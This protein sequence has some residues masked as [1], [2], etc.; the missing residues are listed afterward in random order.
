[1]IFFK[2]YLI[3]TIVITIP[4]LI[5][6]YFDVQRMEELLIKQ[7]EQKLLEIGIMLQQNLS[8]SF[9]F[10]VD[11]ENNPNLKEEEKVK[12]LN[13]KIQPIIMKISRLYPGYGLGYYS[14]RLNQ[15]LAIRPEFNPKFLVKIDPNSPLLKS[16]QSRKFEII[17]MNTSVVWEGKP[18]LGVTSPVYRNGKLIG[19]TWGSLEAED[20][21][22]LVYLSLTKRV[23]ITIL[24]WLIVMFVIWWTFHKLQLTLSTLAAQIRKEDDSSESLK[25]FPELLPVLETI[26]AL[27]KGLKRK[28]NILRWMLEKIPGGVI[29]IDANQKVT[30]ANPS[31]HKILGLDK[32]KENLLGKNLNYLTQLVGIHDLK[33]AP[34][35]QALKD[36]RFFSKAKISI[37]N[38][39]CQFDASPIIDPQSGK[40]IGAATYFTDVTEEE[41][42]NKELE[43]ITLKYLNEAQNLQKLVDTAPLGIISIDRLGNILTVNQTYL[44]YFPSL[45]ETN[46]IG[47]PFRMV[48]QMANYS[49]EQAPITQALKGREIREAFVEV[50]GKKLFINAY[51]IRNSESQEILGAMAIAKDI[52]EQE[53]LQKEMERM[54]RLKLLGKMAASLAHEIRNP[55][56]VIRSFAQ[57]LMTKTEEPFQKSFNLI[58][59]ELDR[60]NQVIGDFLSLARNKSVEKSLCNLNSIISDIYPLLEADALKRDL[61]ID[62]KLEENLPNL[63]LSQKGIKQL[64]LNLSCNGMDAMNKGGCLTLSTSFQED[65]VQLS[66]SD[67]GCGIPEEKL[68]NLFEPFHTTKES[69]TGLGLPVCL[70]IVEQ[71]GAKID[72]QSEKSSGTTFI[73][74][75]SLN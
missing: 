55:L 4:M 8:G 49:Y 14:K 42:K 48:T 13:G 28:N 59:Q 29:T 56:T 16:Y 24:V 17:Q 58:L 74:K 22:R 6:S 20:I 54:D 12:I 46:L 61:K 37:K 7:E 32:E 35:F 11:T 60:A 3:I 30:I 65:G 75:F 64:L 63:C 44:N 62:L 66:I 71:H 70:S 5:F 10:I 19:H 73:I 34:L 67:T 41:I 9:N 53:R 27:R 69:G 39:I 21:N 36:G 68:D 25:D 50:F 23:F 2:V 51:P 31:S 40:T 38:R 1:M 52:A 15:V 72:V 26:A 45:K 57:I 33:E 18:I 43:E 47:K